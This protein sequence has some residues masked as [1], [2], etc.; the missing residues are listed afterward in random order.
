MH[1]AVLGISIFHTIV[2]LDPEIKQYNIIKWVPH[3]YSDAD[4]NY[5]TDKDILSILI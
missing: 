1:T 3:F 4:H 2:H 5:G